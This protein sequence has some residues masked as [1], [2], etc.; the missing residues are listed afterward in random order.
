MDVF[1][2]QAC[3]Y[4][5]ASASFLT[6]SSMAEQ[7]PCLDVQTDRWNNFELVQCTSHQTTTN[8]E[9]EQKYIFEKKVNI[10]VI[11]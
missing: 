2:I 9:L 10:D 1:F 3:L 6:N 7:E 11:L 4:T 5:F 8:I